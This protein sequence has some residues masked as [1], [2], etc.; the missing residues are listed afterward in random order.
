M[1]SGRRVAV[2]SNRG[3]TAAAVREAVDK[4]GILAGLTASSRVSIKPNFTWPSYRPGITTSP[5]VIRELVRVVRDYTTRIAIVESDGGYG[6]WSATQAFAGHGL[7]AIQ[8]ELGVELVNLCDEPREPLAFLSQ[9]RERTVPL[10]QRLLHETDLFI[11]MPVPKIH[12]M[13]GLTL[14]HKNQWG[15]VPDTMRLRSHY[16][17]NDAIVAINKRLRPAVVGDGTYFLDRNGPMDGDPVRMDL[18]LAAT[19]AG[20][21]DRY[22]SELMRFDWRKV[23]HL[24]RS[25]EAGLLPREL[26]E[27]QFDVHP[28]ELSSH[29]FKLVRSPRNW[30]ALSGFNSRFITWFGYES[31][32]GRVVLHGI[33][34]AIVGAP[35]RPSAAAPK[36][37]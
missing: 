20:A 19:D 18:I 24:K 33:L 11:T 14:A 29:R 32:F 7:E 4:S 17:F 26:S 21:F 2:A 30:I 3:D 37:G 13:T 5:E 35:V 12:S 15:C 31:W 16:I 25:A 6:M 34:Y 27:I 1:A 9:G 10:P 36:V 28:H 23:T 22:V 8:R